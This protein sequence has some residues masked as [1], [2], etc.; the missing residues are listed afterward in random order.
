MNSVP[1]KVVQFWKYDINRPAGKEWVRVKE[2]EKT[3]D[4]DWWKD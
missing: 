2:L 4:V 3:I 1:L